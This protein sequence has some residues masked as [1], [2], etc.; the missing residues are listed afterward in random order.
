MLGNPTTRT[1]P[2]VRY[3]NNVIRP[4]VLL[5]FAVPACG[6]TLEITSSAVQR[7]SAGVVRI[8][9]KPNSSKPLAALQFELAVPDSLEIRASDV[10]TG[11][12]ADTVGKSLTCALRPPQPKERICACILAGGR[13]TLRAGTIILVK[14]TAAQKA[15]AGTVKLHMRKVAGVSSAMETT[16]IADADAT[17]TVH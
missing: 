4:I 11:S 8:V 5:I 10:V 13:E 16:P 12:A 14:I 1:P 15:P 2:G 7:G 9:L 17:I 3:S 6:Q